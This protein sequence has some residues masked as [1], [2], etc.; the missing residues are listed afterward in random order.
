MD[1]HQK[2][3]LKEL[4]TKGKEQGFLTY[5]EVNDHLPEGIVEPEQI[6]DIIRMINDMGIDVHESA[7]A[8]VNEVPIDT[9]TGSDE[10]AAEMGKKIECRICHKFKP[11]NRKYFGSTASGGLRRQC[12][13]CRRKIIQ[14]H[15]AKDR[16]KGRARAAK[17]TAQEGHLDWKTR[18]RAAR[19]LSIKQDG[20]CY[21]CGTKLNMRDTGEHHVDHKLP[22]SRGGM[23]DID[24]LA[25][26]CKQCNK[27]KSNKTEEEYRLWKI[28]VGL[29]VICK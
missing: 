24:N 14:E 6:E 10:D 12:R 5:T 3:R 28:K 26:T 27:E 9:E 21:Y 8:E 19:Q 13:D 7:P 17:R 11:A 22:V 2:S 29:P 23:G 15:E 18:E 4:I 1:Q 16:D 20:K 25:L